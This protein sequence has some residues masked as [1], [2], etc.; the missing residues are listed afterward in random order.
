MQESVGWEK[1]GDWEKEQIGNDADENDGGH[2][3]KV[4]YQL[5]LES[6]EIVKFFS[7][8]KYA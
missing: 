5:Y 4:L 8:E 3:W 7:W 6:F 1:K 2:V